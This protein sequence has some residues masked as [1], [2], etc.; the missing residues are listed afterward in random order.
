MDA[1]AHEA[2]GTVLD[3]TEDS[4]ELL[5]S[6]ISSGVLAHSPYLALFLSTYAC[7]SVCAKDIRKTNLFRREGDN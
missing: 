4:I 3:L 2:L 6:T 7:L 5:E 1:R